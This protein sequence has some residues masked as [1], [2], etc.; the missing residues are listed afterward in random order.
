MGRLRH[1]KARRL[2]SLVPPVRRSPK[3]IFRKSLSETQHMRSGGGLRH[4][5][6]LRSAAA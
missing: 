4:P 5:R 3:Q 1:V 6:P 2:P